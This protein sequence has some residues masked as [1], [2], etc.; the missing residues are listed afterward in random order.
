MEYKLYHSTHS[1]SPKSSLDGKMA[2]LE[3]VNVE[4][5]MENAEF[6]RSRAE[7]DYSQV[8]LHSFLD[9]N[10]KSQPPHERMTKLEAKNG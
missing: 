2:E 5:V 4:L 7:I 1:T 8:G 6:R 10:E 9:Q 3:R